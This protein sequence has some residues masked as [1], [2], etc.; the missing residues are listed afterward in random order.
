MSYSIGELAKIVGMTVHGLRFYE[1][2]GLVT[3]E[4]QGK[5]R[6]YSE[7]DKKWIEFLIHMKETGMSIEDMKKYTELRQLED[8]PVEELMQLYFYIEKRYKNS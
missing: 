5:N 7:E 2:E 8:P 4:R 6:I 1:K 3:P